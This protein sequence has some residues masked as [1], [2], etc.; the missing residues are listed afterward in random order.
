MIVHGNSS[1]YLNM[2]V[3]KK[4]NP[5]PSQTASQI[6]PKSVPNRSQIG[7][8]S[9]QIDPETPPGHLQ[10]PILAQGCPKT[11]KRDAQGIP[12]DPL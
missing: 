1:D 5:K 4:N 9:S 7:T 6:D 3:N 2:K 11:P 12:K 8:K 10:G